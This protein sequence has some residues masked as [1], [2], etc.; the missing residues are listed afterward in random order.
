[1]GRDEQLMMV[2]P[3]LDLFSLLLM[4]RFHIHTPSCLD[5]ARHLQKQLDAQLDS[6]AYRTIRRHLERCP[7]CAA[8]LD[9]LKKCILLYRRYPAPRIP[10][11]ARQ[12][13]RTLLKLPRETRP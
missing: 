1:V 3:P 10:D 12:R 5:V 2:V 13:L 8:Y 4:H 11:G 7:N 9:S 6:S